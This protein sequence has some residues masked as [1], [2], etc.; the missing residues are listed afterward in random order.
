VASNQ[1]RVLGAHL[2][3][4]RHS[5]MDL[6]EERVH[7]LSR[8]H[9][10]VWY[11]ADGIYSMYGDLAP[12]D[13]LGELLERFERFHLYVDDA[14]GMSWRGRHGRGATLDR[15]ALH[16]RMVMATSLNKSFAAAGGALVFPDPET[17]RRVRTCAGPLLFSGPIQP[18]MLGAAVASARIHLSEEIGELQKRLRDRMLTCHQLLAGCGLPVLSAAVAPIQF[19]GLGL[20]KV[21]QNLTAQLIEEGFYAN[22]AQFPAV[23]MRRAGVRL[24]LTLHQTEE[25]IRR[26]VEAI[27]RNADAA[28]AAE[29]ESREDAWRAFELPPPDLVG[30]DSPRERRLS[31]PIR[32]G[33]ADLALAT[34]FAPSVARRRRALRLERADSIED[35]APEQWDPFLGD[36]GSFT[37]EG[38][39][40]LERTFRD[41]PRLENRWRFHYYRVL[42]PGGRTILLTFFTQGLWKDDMLA[43]ASVSREMERLRGSDRLHG[44][45]SVFSMGSLLTEGDH[46]YLARSAS[47]PS[48]EQALSLL[49]AAIRE[50]GDAGGAEMMVLRDL[51]ADDPALDALLRERDFARMPVP[52]SFEVEPSWKDQEDFIRRL[53]RKSRQHQRRQV[54]PWNDA[55]L[56]EILGSSTREPSPDEFGH[57]RRLYLNVKARALE[58]NTFDLP[59]EIFAKMCGFPSWEFIVLNP[60]PEFALDPTRQREPVAMVACFAGPRQYVPLVIGLD[61]DYVEARGLY[62]QCLRHVL[63][64]ARERGI[65]RVLLGVGASREKRRFGARPAQSVLYVQARDHFASDVIEQMSTRAAV[66]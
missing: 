27:D 45:T 53:S 49:L 23:P 22:V 58:L 64:R 13:A 1:V 47:T 48:G 16:P 19:V 66:G 32:D 31:L 65:P 44:T 62:R 33:K 18:P 21:A 28:L 63:E 61:Y 14:H 40:F 2:E 17:K 42:D 30:R 50:D 26:V 41:H 34:R 51:P 52:Q 37:H 57:F 5:R 55:Y 36:R 43:S 54:L 6:L 56:V 8:Q 25:D 29:G 15:M 35:F 12:V 3:L 10:H 7:E 11:M 39:R 20:T 4:L 38:L 60:R 46:L 24:A 9:R 59:E